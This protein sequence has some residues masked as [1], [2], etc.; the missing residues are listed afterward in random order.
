[1]NSVIMYMLRWKTIKIFITNLGKCTQIDA[2]PLSDE[3]LKKYPYLKIE[4]YVMN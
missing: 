3:V 4:K 2:R 1:M